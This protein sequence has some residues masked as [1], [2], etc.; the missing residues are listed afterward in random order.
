VT[1]RDPD[2]RECLKGIELEALPA[3]DE[4][5]LAGV[6]RLVQHW[7]LAREVRRCVLEKVFAFWA[8]ARTGADAGA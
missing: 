1:E 4:S 6:G 3:I 8:D 2:V 5:E 7:R